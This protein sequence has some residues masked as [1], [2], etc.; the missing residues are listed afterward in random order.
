MLGLRL[1]T[2][3]CRAGVLS[4]HP[5]FTQHI[6]SSPN[7]NVKMLDGKELNGLSVADD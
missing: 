5:L 6:I 3:P 2:G 4:F 1:E 7:S